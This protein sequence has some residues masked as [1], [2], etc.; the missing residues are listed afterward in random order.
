[1][2]FHPENLKAT[3]AYELVRNGQC[4]QAVKV[5]TAAGYSN[6]DRQVKLIAGFLAHCAK[7]PKAFRRRKK[8]K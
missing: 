6:P 7:K 4:D 5:L 3:R 2:I 8:N 1:M